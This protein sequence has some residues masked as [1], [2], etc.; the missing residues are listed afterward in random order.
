M[1]FSERVLSY[2]GIHRCPDWGDWSH[3]ADFDLPYA[4]RHSML[5]EM[6]DHDGNAW[7]CS[8][9]RGR[10][11]TTAPLE[12]RLEMPA[13]DG[14]PVASPG[15]ASKCYRP[16]ENWSLQGDLMCS[17]INTASRA[18]PR[19]RKKCFGMIEE[20]CKTSRSP[21]KICS[22]GSAQFPWIYIN[23]LYL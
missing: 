23:S 21:R 8:T 4:T 12:S 11:R 13:Y 1:I 3:S 19:H 10:G 15:R 7:H 17:S 18:A 14:H 20:S 6:E 22:P 2:P 5:T 16:R 9:L